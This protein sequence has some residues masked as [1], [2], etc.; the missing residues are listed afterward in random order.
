MNLVL[1]ETSGN[2]AFIFATNKLRENVGASELTARVGT[3]FVL[4]AVQEAG[5]QLPSNPRDPATYPQ[6]SDQNLVEVILAVSGKALLLVRDADLGRQIVR[7]VTLCALKE[8]PGLEVRGVVSRDFDF[9]KDA[10]HPLVGEVHREF[11]MVRSKLPGPVAR[12]QRLPIIAECASS[13]LPASNYDVSGPEPA[14]RSA[15]ILAKR[16]AAQAG[17]D[18]IR[19]LVG[20]EHHLPRSTTEIENLGCDWLAIVHADGNGL[21][22]VFLTFDQVAQ[23]TNHR[24]YI[25]K[26]RAFSLAL[27]Q[28]TE[29]AFCQSL[30]VL[31]DRQ[32][33]TPIVPLVLGGDD[34]TVVC[35]GRQ[36]LQ[37]TKKFIDGFE[38]ETRGHAAINS[39]LKNGVTSCAGVAIVKPHFPFFAGYQLAEELLK[40]AKALKPLSAI[41]YH[42]LYDASGPD[43]ERIRRELTVDNGETLLVGRPYVTTAERGPIQRRWSDLVCRITA[44]RARDDEDRRRLPNSMLHDLRQGLFLGHQAAD[45]RLQLVVERYRHHGLDRLLGD[46]SSEGSLFWQDSD[47]RRTAL[48]DTLDTAEFWEARS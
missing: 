39:I 41:D 23:T 35:D 44:V 15:V 7:A 42:I 29:K 46:T 26:L 16:K 12:F 36:A 2:Q 10:L 27:D 11:E 5:G 18:R 28:C 45:A 9:E 25:T 14:P 17:L 40:S 8:A 43:L 4:K 1:I 31:R 22:Q 37:F 34:L 19:G 21:G 33:I 47:F 30:A 6:I 3:R 24:D 32:G 20:E 48:L 38:E 13:G